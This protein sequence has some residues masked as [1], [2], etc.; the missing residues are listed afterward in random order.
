MEAEGAGGAAKSQ[1]WIIPAGVG[2][3]SLLPPE[4]IAPVLNILLVTF[5]FFALVLAGFVA[6]QRKMLPLEAIPGLNGFVLF[7]AL[8]CLL[9]RFGSTTPIAELLDASV[10]G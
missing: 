7:F 1:L 5:P 3:A 4:T 8:P 10:M 9:Y 2:A 6:A